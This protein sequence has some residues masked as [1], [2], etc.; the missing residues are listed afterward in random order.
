LADQRPDPWTV[1]GRRAIY[2]S[3]WVEL[4][5]DDVEDSAGRRFDHHV[6]RVP[7]EAVTVAILNA[8][9]E[10]L[11]MY[12]HRFIPDAYQWELPSGWIDPD[13][14]PEDAARREA[15][16]ETGWQPGE[17][18]SLGTCNADNGLVQLRSHLYYTD[19]AT[20]LGEPTD[21]AETATLAWF[22]L[23]RVQQLID[24]DLVTDAPILVTLLRVLLRKGRP[25]FHL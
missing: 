21:P 3:P 12:R 20:H 5:L 13:E 16:E 18:H 15:A 11:M 22:P 24:D 19:D 10:V 6:V 4:W 17:L 1:H 7:R 2:Q 8:A 14:K 25:S 23:G 9:G